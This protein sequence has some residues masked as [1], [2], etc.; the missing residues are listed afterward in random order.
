MQ[1]FSIKRIGALWAIPAMFSLSLQAQTDLS[2]EGLSMELSPETVDLPTLIRRGL[3]QNFQLR[4]VRNQERIANQNAT[5]ANAGYLPK[6]N[7]NA[8]YSGSLQSSKST[9]RQTGQSQKDANSLNHNVNAGVFAEWTIFDGLK[10]QTNYK[11]LQ[12]LRRMSA[13]QTRLTLENYVADLST[14]YYNLIQQHIRLANLEQAMNL[15][16]ERLHIVEFTCPHSLTF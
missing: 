4:I 12:E 13:T 1:K 8:G 10:I 14:A 6:V 15:S 5:R 7:L 9:P 16:K 2:A 3:D 11:R